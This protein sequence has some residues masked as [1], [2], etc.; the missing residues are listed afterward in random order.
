M[1]RY[2]FFRVPP[3]NFGPITL[4]EFPKA[5]DL[6]DFY[7]LLSVRAQQPE[8]GQWHPEVN[9]VEYSYLNEELA[10]I[11]DE[12]GRFLQ[13]DLPNARIMEFVRN[14][15]NP[16]PLFGTFLI[17]SAKGQSMA[18]SALRDSDILLIE[19]LFKMRGLR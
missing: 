10:L 17:S 12:E 19:S 11:G 1:K 4:I 16:V 18:E 5:P 7:S 8:G 13:G 3:D 14:F 9:M 15:G 6:Y 2:R